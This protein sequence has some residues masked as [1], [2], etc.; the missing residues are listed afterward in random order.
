MTLVDLTGQKFG[1]LVVIDKSEKLHKTPNGTTRT[2]WNCKCSCGNIV[3]LQGIFLRSGRQTS[4]G[5]KK[6]THQASLTSEYH[7]WQGM[8]QRCGNPCST[9]YHSYGA[10][11]IR[12]CE[13]WSDDFEAFLDYVGPRPT[14][15][16]S[17]DR[18][19]VNGHYE[20]G[21]VRWSTPFEQSQNK[22]N[23]HSV[24][25]YSNKYQEKTRD[26]A[27]YPSQGE[28]DGISYCLLGLCGEVGELSSI[29]CKKMRNA[30]YI[31]TIEDKQKMIAELGDVAWFMSQLANELGVSL[32][33]VFQYNITKLADRKS[34]NVLQ[35]S[36]DNR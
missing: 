9:S 29:H 5:C 18:I 2:I 35:G 32:S 28:F 4:C 30:D 15:D 34:R 12:V 3:E 20:P 22:R 8:K 16:H 11:G 31:Y 13:E 7:I 25:V 10:R 33:S 14:K 24:G 26:T 21:N 1:D 23:E 36:G 19:D 6:T 27:I 17:I